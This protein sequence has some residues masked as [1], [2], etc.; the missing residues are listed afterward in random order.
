MSEV[1]VGCSYRCVTCLGTQDNCTVCDAYKFRV[2]PPTCF[3]Q[4]K[5]FDDGTP[6]CK[7]CAYFC[8]QCSQVASNCTVC[9]ATKFRVLDA[10]T[11]TCK[12]MT[13]YFDD[14][15]HEVCG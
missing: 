2:S 12:C 3:C 10:A 4:D 8:S 14:G 13:K 11:S 9:D 7:P 1:C 5:Y 6:E 15:I